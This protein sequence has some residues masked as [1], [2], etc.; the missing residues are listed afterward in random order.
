MDFSLSEK[1]KMLK[2][3]TRKFAEEFIV[4]VARES[5]EKQELNDNVFQKMK[6][7]NLANRWKKSC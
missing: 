2:N 5:D 4:P 6:G 3:V 7:M 1:Q